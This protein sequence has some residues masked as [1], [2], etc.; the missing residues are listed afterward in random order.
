MMRNMDQKC[1][2]RNRAG[3][4]GRKK[5]KTKTR[6]KRG[7]LVRIGVSVPFHYGRHAVAQVWSR[8]VGR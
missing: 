6:T 7:R 4:G 3:G 5:R 8:A 2:G 1:T